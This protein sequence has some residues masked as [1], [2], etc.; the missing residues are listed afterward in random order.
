MT[1]SDAGDNASSLLG[2]DCTHV[3]VVASSPAEFALFELK[4]RAIQSLH[5]D[6]VYNIFGVHPSGRRVFV[7]HQLR[8]ALSQSTRDWWDV[9]EKYLREGILIQGQTNQ[10][11][12]LLQDWLRKFRMYD[13]DGTVAKSKWH[14]K[15]SKMLDKRF[16]MVQAVRGM[17]QTLYEQSPYIHMMLAEPWDVSKIQNGPHSLSYEGME[18]IRQHAVPWTIEYSALRESFLR[19]PK[20]SLEGVML[21]PIS[22]D[23]APF[24]SK[25]ID[26]ATWEGLYNVLSR[27]GTVL[28][29]SKTIPSSTQFIWSMFQGVNRSVYS[30]S[31][32][33]GTPKSSHS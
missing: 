14:G 17:D 28:C 29:W 27:T 3:S 6:N 20:H 16:S 33:V 30:G 10:Q 1:V 31:P 19:R 24:S 8:T 5:P 22:E 32:W 23:D 21:G 9:H 15:R 25:Y 11:Q 2:L 7:Y 4:I 26:E 12:I 18:K 13:K